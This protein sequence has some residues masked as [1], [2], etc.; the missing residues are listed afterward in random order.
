[1]VPPRRFALLFAAATL[2]STAS[3]AASARQ[4]PA[5]DRVSLWPGGYYSHD[6]SRRR[7]PAR[8]RASRASSASRMISVSRTTASIRARFDFLLGD[9]RG[10]SFDYY[11]IHRDRNAAY[12]GHSSLGTDIGAHVRA[13]LEYD[14]DAAYY[15]VSFRVSGT[16]HTGDEAG[17]FSDSYDE[18]AWAPMLTLGWRHAFSDQ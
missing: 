14:F 2:L 18:S 15:E 12:A 17:S 8:T 4:S 5:L 9:N 11:R 1:M 7:K 6:D 16:A 13:T 10:F 3:F